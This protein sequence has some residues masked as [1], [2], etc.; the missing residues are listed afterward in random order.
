MDEAK[1]QA[2]DTM[3]TALNPVATVVAT[4]PTTQTVQ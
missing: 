2:A 1:Q 3:D 4:V